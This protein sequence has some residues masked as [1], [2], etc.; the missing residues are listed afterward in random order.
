M[1]EGTLHLIFHTRGDSLTVNIRAPGG[2]HFRYRSRAVGKRESEQKD[3]QSGRCK[4]L[5]WGADGERLQT[6]I[7]IH[8]Q[9]GSVRWRLLLPADY[10]LSVKNLPTVFICL[11]CLCV[12]SVLNFFLF[13]GGGGSPWQKKPKTA[14][15]KHKQIWSTVDDVHF[16]KLTFFF[17]ECVNYRNKIPSFVV[18]SWAYSGPSL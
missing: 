5:M 13:F 14:T 2:S 10:L 15:T 3:K 6:H 9:R 18:S 16:S 11:F 7:N 8:F 4:R 1:L 17:G 12:S